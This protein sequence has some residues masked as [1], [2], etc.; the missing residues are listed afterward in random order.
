MTAAIEC[1]RAV[2]LKEANPIHKNELIE[3]LDFISRI[4]I[5]YETYAKFYDKFTPLNIETEFVVPLGEI[6][7]ACGKEYPNDI[8]WQTDI[9]CSACQAEIHYWAGKVDLTVN[10]GGTFRIWDH[11]TTKSA[12][13]TYLDSWK[14]SMQML[15]YVYG[16]GKATGSKVTGYTVNILKKIKSVGD[17]RTRTKQCPSCKN[18]ARK[19]PS[20]QQCRA[21]GRVERDY[22]SG[23]GAFLR[24]SN[25]VTED[26]LERFV[27]TRLNTANQITY[28]REIRTGEREPWPMNPSACHLMGKCPF[29]DLCWHG[30]PKEWYLP[31]NGLLNNFDPRPAD[32]VSVKQMLQEERI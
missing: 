27:R 11:K 32:Y 4:L 20:C 26:D 14:Y 30:N 22:K 29:V 25:S 31:H 8:F 9:A 17:E 19:R 28:A 23:D 7:W 6:C 2:E 24:V 3:D 15:G 12:G 16:Y 18:G 13:D 21:T 1:V 10:E 5:A